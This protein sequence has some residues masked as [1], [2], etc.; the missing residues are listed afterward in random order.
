MSWYYEVEVHPNYSLQ[1]I[2]TCWYTYSYKCKI[3]NFCYFHGKSKVIYIM[4]DL[5]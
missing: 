3:N 4:Y 2:K 1:T 5:I